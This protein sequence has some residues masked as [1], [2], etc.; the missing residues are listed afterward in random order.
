MVG[1]MKFPFEKIPFW[2]DMIIFWGV[3]LFDL[4]P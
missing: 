2:V 4:P 3:P 1:K